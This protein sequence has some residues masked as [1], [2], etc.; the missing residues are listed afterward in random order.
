MKRVV[1]VGVL[2]AIV[3]L[4][5]FAGSEYWKLPYDPTS[6][7][8]V[9]AWMTDYL[10][11][12]EGQ[13]YWQAIHPMDVLV[14]HGFDWIKAGMTINSIP[15]F[16]L[17]S[18][19]WPSI[20][21]TDKA[22]QCREMTAL[23]LEEAMARGMKICLQLVMS[24]TATHG[25]QQ[26]CP[27][28]W[29]GLSLSELVQT[30]EDHA[31]ASVSYILERGI[32]LDMIEIGNEIEPGLPCREAGT[33]IPEPPGIDN[34]EKDIAW[35]RRDVWP[36]E[37]QLLKAALRGAR[38][39]APGVPTTTHVSMLY[40]CD[41]AV[42]FF[43]VMAEQDVDLDY[44]GF[45]LPYPLYP[46]VRQESMTRD[47]WYLELS[48]TVDAIY[49]TG[50]PVLIGEFAYPFRVSGDNN[51]TMFG[52]PLTPDGQ[53]DYV[54]DTLRFASN[55]PHVDG[56]FYWNP[57]AFPGVMID[58]T[59]DLLFNESLGLFAA[60][61]VPNPAMAEF[62]VNLSASQEEHPLGP[63]DLDAVTSIF[64]PQ[65]EATS[66]LPDVANESLLEPVVTDISENYIRE[67]RKQSETLPSAEI[68]VSIRA[69]IATGT[70]SPALRLRAN[71]ETVWT[72]D[73]AETG[74]WQIYETEITAHKGLA[75]LSVGFA[76][77]KECAHLSI[78]YVIV[79]GERYDLEDL[80]GYAIFG[81]APEADP[82]FITFWGLGEVAWQVDFSDEDA[83]VELEEAN[84]GDDPNALDFRYVCIGQLMHEIF[85]DF[86]T[87]Y[88]SEI[89]DALQ[90]IKDLGFKGVSANFTYYLDVVNHRVYPCHEQGS[91]GHPWRFSPQDW[92]IEALYECI[93]DVGLDA[94]LRLEVVTPQAD[95]GGRGS[96]FDYA[97][98]RSNAQRFFES[99]QELAVR[100]ARILERTDADVFTVFQELP[101]IE[102]H[103]DLVEA[104]LDAVAN[105]FSGDLI[106]EQHTSGALHEFPEISA[107]GDTHAYEDSSGDY[108]DWEHPDG[109]KV[110]IGYS[111]W[112]GHAGA[113]SP[114]DNFGIQHSSNMEVIVSQI[115]RTWQNLVSYHRARYPGHLIVFSEVGIYNSGNQWM[116]D[117]WEAYLTAMRRMRVDG[118][119]VWSISLEWM[120]YGGK[121]LTYG[122]DE[123]GGEP[124]ISAITQFLE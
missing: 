96:R 11:H 121:P 2:A 1:L 42:E 88:R 124:V 99:Y 49:E 20:G 76:P 38:R 25:G 29:K 61:G 71:G 64:L 98:S 56:L 68:P 46:G 22:W 106:V 89:M 31:Y 16:E 100:I 91:C 92:M 9:G 94:D 85:L 27:A 41:V 36:V 14:A 52:Y 21:W 78:D 77:P 114:A 105:V 55:H 44:A 109:R 118:F 79:G 74:Q 107:R 87:T 10:V 112:P 113:Y 37:A 45:S 39:A 75:V 32:R 6:G 50:Y 7:L 82:T 5:A 40:T 8:I 17:P 54:R 120:P 122:H 13:G 12:R 4:S 23:V 108:W 93:R 83:P 33:D 15:E 111:W 86:P 67:L 58:D 43:E 117:M 3:S 69:K 18:S 102:R 59:P 63:T 19:M 80:D 95:E 104:T 81:P 30:Y 34:M 66:T 110:I 51:A 60:D 123:I 70:C 48:A 72:V 65:R 26:P 97:P 103:S 24:D 119:S 47:E 57:N 90:A 35:L 28:E 84:W 101:M 116:A 62:E 73:V 53:A 115:V